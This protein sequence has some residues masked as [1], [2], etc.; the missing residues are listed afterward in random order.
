MFVWVKKKIG[1]KKISGSKNYLGQKKI[2]K[3]LFGSKKKF[4]QKEI[5]VKEM[6]KKILGQKN[7]WVK[8]NFG[9][10]KI[11][12]QNIFGLKSF[13]VKKFK[14]KKKIGLKRFRSETQGG[15]FMN[16]C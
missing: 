5:W 9:S 7:V 14:G 12:D 3:N 6:V 1:S 4:C 11:L 16:R 2:V 13:W 10:S 8:N 15:K